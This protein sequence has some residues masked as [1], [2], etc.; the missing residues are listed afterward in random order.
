MTKLAIL[1]LLVLSAPALGQHRMEAPSGGIVGNVIP[2][3]KTGKKAVVNW[4][5]LTRSET[6]DW[7]YRTDQMIRKNGNVLMWIMT[8][9]KGELGYQM[10][11]WAIRCRERQA[12]LAEFTGYTSNHRVKFRSK[13]LEPDWQEIQS[14]TL[15]GVTR[16]KV[17]GRGK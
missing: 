11:L 2:V 4:L 17:C 5:P 8:Q 9:T 10:N 15:L 3:V 6:D 14:N 13:E 16:D 12:S 7:F 1:F